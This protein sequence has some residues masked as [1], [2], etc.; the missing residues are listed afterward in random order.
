VRFR[1]ETY[2]SEDKVVSIYSR[3]TSTPAPKITE[4][5]TERLNASVLDSAI[6]SKPD[7]VCFSHLRWD[8]VYQRPQHF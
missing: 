7:L 8:W 2:F 4:A 5:V 3:Y 1:A 6:Q